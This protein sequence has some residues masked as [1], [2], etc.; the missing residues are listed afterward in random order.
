MI[1]KL[2]TRLISLNMIDVEN[3]NRLPTDDE[4]QIAKSIEEHGLLQPVGVAVEGHRF[5]LLYGATRL[6]AVQSLGRDQIK[7]I[8]FEG[9]AEELAN[10]EFVENLERRNYTKEQ[11]EDLIKAYVDSRANRTK[12]EELNDSLSQNSSPTSKGHPKKKVEGAKRGR[13]P[14]PEGQAKKEAAE[15]TGISVRTVQRATG[16]G[17]KKSRDPGAATPNRDAGRMKAFDDV[18]G[19]IKAIS[20]LLPSLDR[21]DREMIRKNNHPFL[22][23]WFDSQGR[24]ITGEAAGSPAALAPARDDASLQEEPEQ[25]PIQPDASED[26]EPASGE[27]EPDAETVVNVKPDGRAANTDT[28][29]TTGTCDG[30]AP[31]GCPELLSA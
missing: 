8:I 10:A 21:T 5:R 6:R 23:G 20:K 24:L 7:S 26:G 3:R 17:P 27:A 2:G 11:R 1:T 18:A 25:A 15:K 19:H 31:R 16:S 28:H 13:P 9:P 14:T 30:P 29:D 22:D 4:V 12:P